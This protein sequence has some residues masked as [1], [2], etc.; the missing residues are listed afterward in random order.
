MFRFEQIAS[1]TRERAQEISEELSFPGRIE[2]DD[3]IGQARLLARG[4]QTEF[5]QRASAGKVSSSLGEADAG[6]PGTEPPRLDA[7][8]GG[9][10]D[11]LTLIDGVGNAIEETLFK[12]GIYHFDQ[13]A[14]WSDDEC[15]WIGR[16]IRFPG[17]PQRENWREEAR[18][19]ASG[20]TTEHARRV[21]EGRIATSRRSTDE[22]K[23]E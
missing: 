15:I 12:L 11:N 5:S 9:K 7:A 16:R 17:R 14:A 23:G 22:E 21:E 1:W 3:W 10:P 18:I 19:L 4:E 8:R 6:E 2:R 20:G 13:I